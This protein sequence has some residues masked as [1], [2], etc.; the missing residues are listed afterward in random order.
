[1][2]VT[3]VSTCLT[4]CLA[5]MTFGTGVSAHPVMDELQTMPPGHVVEQAQY[6]RFVPAPVY[7][8]PVYVPPVRYYSPPVY[9]AP[10][11]RAPVYRTPAYRTPAYR[12][13]TVRPRFSSYRSTYRSASPR[14]RI[15]S[16][17]S[18]SRGNYREIGMDR[19][20]RVRPCFSSRRTGSCAFR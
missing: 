4:I 7:R 11:Y 20:G 3:I 19:R 17:R 15:L 9:R 14:A 16:S 13:S 10:V 2:R 1:M 18:A 5:V 12:A 8:P 6:R